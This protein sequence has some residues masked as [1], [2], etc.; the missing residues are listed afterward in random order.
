MG[1]YRGGIAM[2][3]MLAPLLLITAERGVVNHDATYAGLGARQIATNGTVWVDDLDLTKL[4]ANQRPTEDF[5]LRV[6]D[7]GRT[8]VARTMGVVLAGVP[9]YWLF[10]RGSDSADL[11]SAPAS[12]TAAFLT[13]LAL[14]MLYLALRPR[15]GDA[16]AALA[17]S[18]AGLSTP[19]WSVN[20]DMLWTHSVTVVGLT[21]MALAVSRDRWWLAGVA[22]GVAL[23]GRPH[24]ALIV[25]VVGVGLAVWR[26][27]PSI[28]VKMGLVSAGFL[29]LLMLWNRW[30]FGV[31]SAEGAYAA[32]D[33][34]GMALGDGALSLERLAQQA[35]LWV[36]PSVGLLVWTPVLTVLL[37]AVAIHRRCL[38]DWSQVLVAGGTLYALAQGQVAAFHGGDGFYGYRLMLEPL[39]CFLPA[40]LLVIPILGPRVR[41]AC[42][43]LVGLQLAAISTGAVRKSW[44]VLRE[45]GWT[46]NG[47]ALALTTE[48][49]LVIWML[50]M[51]VFGAL[52]AA[53]LNR[54]WLERT[55]R[56]PAQRTLPI[57][58][59]EP[60]AEV[61]SR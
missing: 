30:V 17:A 11:R 23:L 44:F 14:V 24:V 56:A 50:V 43:A 38:P 40:A 46:Q 13:L 10:N 51:T 29:G 31:W 57:Q 39:V 34:T 35:G 45:D 59:S 33:V 2:L 53:V 36:A 8:A 15:W 4:P 5:S 27:K 12:W 47:F 25:A 60:Q 18:L 54:R 55:A 61:R 32:R 41:V 21:G 42:G 9:A 52:A 19:L 26:R 20:A 49:E 48:P 1:A 3:A 7:D 28:A 6:R 37:P 22:G 16:W 58:R